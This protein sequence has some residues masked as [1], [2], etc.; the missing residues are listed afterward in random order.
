VVVVGEDFTKLGP[1]VG[2]VTAQEDA[3]ICSPFK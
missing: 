2:S 1:K 3:T